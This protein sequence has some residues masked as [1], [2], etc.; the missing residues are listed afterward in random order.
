[1]STATL[2]R[3]S[4]FDATDRLNEDGTVTFRVIPSNWHKYGISPDTYQMFNGDSWNESEIEYHSEETGRDLGYDDFN[5]D[6]DHRGIVRGLADEAANWIA[7]TLW[8]AGLN[9]VADVRVVDTWSPQFYNFQSDGFEVEI[10]CDPAELRGLTPE[11]DVDSWASEHYRSYD[12]FM[13][14]VT[15]RMNDDDQRAG[16]DAEFRV[17][18]L[19]AANDPYDNREWV[20]RLAEAEWEIY[21]ENVRVEIIE[22]EH[23]DSGYTLPELQEWADSLVSVQTEALF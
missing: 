8:D 10:T 23:L 11:F 16:Y 18:S 13:S 15:S 19:L 14:F 21:S 9:S 1:M 6:Y 12:G 5:W 22:P 3:V 2:E 4:T 7:E 17:E 20:M